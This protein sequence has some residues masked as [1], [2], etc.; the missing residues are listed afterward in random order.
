[1]RKSLVQSLKQLAD[2]RL[3]ILQYTIKVASDL[4]AENERLKVQNKCLWNE[5]QQSRTN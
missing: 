1:M 2:D 5:C 3:K 4:K